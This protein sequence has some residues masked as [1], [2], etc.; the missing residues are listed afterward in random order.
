M[1]HQVPAEL[2]ALVRNTYRALMAQ[3]GGVDRRCQREMIGAIATAV[4]NA[5]KVGDEGTGARLL[6]VNGPTGSGK[7]YGYGIGAIPVALAAGLKV[8][9]STA[10]VSLQEQLTRRDLIALQRVI[11]EM[12]VALVKGRGRYGCPVRIAQLAEGD[13][14]ASKAA[15]AMLSALDAGT[16]SGDVDDLAEQPASDVW[17]KCTNDRAGCAGRKCSAYARCPYYVN[18][19]TIEQANVLVTNHDML[20]ADVRAGHVILPKPA[21]SVFVIDEAHTFPAK[22]VASLADGHTLQDAQQFVM[23]SGALVASIRRADRMGPCGRLA[24]TAMS[25]LEVM[26]GTLSEA[27]MAVESLGKTTDVRDASRP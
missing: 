3:C 9:L 27:Q 20:L 16:W 1:E 11:P 12:R 10:K 18:R 8:V 7:T 13:G 19:K 24:E 2:R 14:E 6:A 21:D 26:G 23:R 25:T 5:K 4:T 22:A 17:A 15:H